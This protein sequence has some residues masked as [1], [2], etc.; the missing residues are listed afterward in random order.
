ME[1]RLLGEGG[2]LVAEV[3]RDLPEALADVL[4]LD[5]LC[6][7]PVPTMR[8][9]SNLE[10]KRWHRPQNS[11]ACEQLS[12]RIPTS[13]LKLA[14]HVGGGLWVSQSMN[15]PASP[16]PT[17]RSSSLSSSRLPAASTPS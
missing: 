2:D 13:F 12:E 9:G 8:A 15:P 7:S 1:F 14:M 6:Q 10:I 5:P 16:V 11:H 3:V 17:D 4:M